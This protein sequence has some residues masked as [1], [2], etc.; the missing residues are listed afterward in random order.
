MHDDFALEI[1]DHLEA[2]RA[3]CERWGM[4]ELGAHLTLI[5]RDPGDPQNAL[6]AGAE[7]LDAVIQTIRHLQ[8]QGIRQG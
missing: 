4:P 5:L 2:I 7:D 3:T 8:G 6:I 1:E